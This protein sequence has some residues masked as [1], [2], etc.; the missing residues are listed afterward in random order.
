MN[1]SLETIFRHIDLMTGK[2]GLPTEKVKALGI[3]CGVPL[4]DKTGIVMSS[5]ARVHGTAEGTTGVSVNYHQYIFRLPPE[6]NRVFPVLLQKV[7]R[8]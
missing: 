5:R 4:D 7:D 2:H 6:Y 8:S 3:R 1:D